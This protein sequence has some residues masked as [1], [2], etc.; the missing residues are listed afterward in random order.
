MIEDGNMHS[1]LPLAALYGYKSTVRLL[2]DQGA[3]IEAT[4][5]KH[6]ALHWAA[7][8]G[9][10]ATVQLLLDRRADIEARSPFNETALHWA[11]KGSHAETVQVLLD[12]GANPGAVDLDRKTAVLCAVENEHEPTVAL[13]TA[14]DPI[15]RAA[16]GH[17]DPRPTW[18]TTPTSG[19]ITLT[20]YNSPTF[21]LERMREPLSLQLV[22]TEPKARSLSSPSPPESPLIRYLYPHRTI[23]RS[24][25]HPANISPS[26]IAF[27]P[28]FFEGS[29]Q[30][31]TAGS[32]ISWIQKTHRLPHPRSQKLHVHKIGK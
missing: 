4:E 27:S 6:T 13:L 12:R 5:F 22:Y 17:R 29:R 15:V 25:S 3:N 14:R 24:Y 11:A 26:Y 9:H 8:E 21:F 7:H 18:S 28:P 23:R 1:A 32:I 19:S 31:S 16:A 10:A 2:L 30:N 20:S